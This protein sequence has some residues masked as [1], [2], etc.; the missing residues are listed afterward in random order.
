[1]LLSRA[2]IFSCMF[3]AILPVVACAGTDNAGEVGTEESELRSSNAC[4]NKKA[5]D[6]CR[7]CPASQPRCVETMEVKSCHAETINHKPALRC[8]SGVQ[9]T[10]YNACAGKA[11]GAHC[12]VCDPNDKTCFETQEVKS[13][14]AKGQCS[15]GEP[16]K[17]YDPCAEKAAGARCTICD[18]KDTDCFEAQVLNTCNAKGQCHPGEPVKP[19]D[20]CANK[21]T[22]QRCTLCDPT[23]STC[24]EAQVLNTCDAKGQCRP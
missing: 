2:I 14:N 10:P 15:A 24:F 8:R 5:G 7:L 1:M 20:P 18:P 6:D 21:A 16:A 3:S 12:T 9:A 4:A 17:A 19:Y 13:C 23:D 22:G 11:T